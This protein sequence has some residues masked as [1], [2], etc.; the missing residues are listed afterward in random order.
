MDPYER[1]KQY[2]LDHGVNPEQ[3][4]ALAALAVLHDRLAE[5]DEADDLRR[6]LRAAETAVQH[7]R[8]L[9]L[10]ER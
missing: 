10:A 3:E 8:E 7:W 1:V 2:I 4:W 5:A 6:R 9:A